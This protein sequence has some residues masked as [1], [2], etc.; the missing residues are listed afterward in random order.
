MSFELTVLNSSIRIPQQE[1]EATLVRLSEAIARNP[2]MQER[3]EVYLFE[4]RKHHGNKP[5]TLFDMLELWGWCSAIDTT[6][7]DLLVLTLNGNVLEEEQTLQEFFD[8]LAPGVDDGNAIEVVIEHVHYRSDAQLSDPYQRTFHRI[9]REHMRCRYVVYQRKMYRLDATCVYPPLETIVAQER[10]V[11][12]PQAGY[13]YATDH[14]RN[15][16]ERVDDTCF[17]WNGERL[18]YSRDFDVRDPDGEEQADAEEL[19]AAHL[20]DEYAKFDLGGHARWIIAFVVESFFQDVLSLP[21]EDMLQLM[22]ALPAYLACWQHQLAEK[23]GGPSEEESA[24]AGRDT[25]L[26]TLRFLY[27]EWVKVDRDE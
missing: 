7:G 24:Q 25:L 11:H 14:G 12:A 20:F 3:A 1:Q 4:Y 10:D 18:S 21:V 6:T 2:L 16:D 15:Q 13:H 17:A 22:E 5:L 23:N 19:I 9:E 27:P 8:L 26:L